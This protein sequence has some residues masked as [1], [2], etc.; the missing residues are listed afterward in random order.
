[1]ILAGSGCRGQGAPARLRAVAERYQCPV[2]TTPK[3]KGVF[4]EDHP[5]SLGVFGLGGH[6]SA[7]AYGE[8]GIDVMVA[9]GTSLG[10][11]A[12]EGWSPLLRGRRAFIHVDIDARPD[13]PQL[14][15][16]PRAGGAGGGVSGRAA[17]ASRCRPRGWSAMA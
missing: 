3:A 12:T 13:R 9:L 14:P 10:D 8:P 16:D 1:M 2:A 7:R 5:L 6:P 11:V 15:A 17:G 4:P